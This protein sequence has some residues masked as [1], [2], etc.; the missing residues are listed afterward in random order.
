MRKWILFSL[1][2]SVSLGGFAGE[3][4]EKVKPVPWEKWNLSPLK[5][6][7]E[8]EVMAIFRNANKYAVNDWYHQVK[9]FSRQK[10]KYLDF[11]GITEHHIRP[12][13]HEA[14]ALGVALKLNVYDK[15]ITG[16]SAEKAEDI[17]LRL[18]TSLAFRHRANQTGKAWGGQ[19]QSALWAAQVATTGWMWWDRLA[20][21]DQEKLC[22]M[23]VDEA[24]RFLGT[25]VP[26]YKDRTGKVIYKGDSKAEENA[27]NSNILVVAAVMMPAHSHRQ[28]WL[29]KALEFQISAYAAPSDIES[30]RKI[31]GIR[32]NIFLQG[33]NLEENGAVVNH[34]IIHAD[35]MCAI[36]H[37][38]LNAWIFGLA[39]EKAPQASLMNGDKVYYALTEYPFA[40]GKTMYVKGEQGEATCR[41]FFPEGNDWGTGRQDGY[42]LMDILA[43]SFGWDKAS[44]VKA[45]EW[46][47]ARHR[48]MLGMQARHTD[49]RSYGEQAENSF[50]SR[51]EW[52]AA[53]I[54]FGYL[55]LWEKANKMVRF[56]NKAIARPL[57]NKPVNY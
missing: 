6:S 20:P 17:V 53:Q 27:W 2:W 13:A 46:A 49:G 26:Y 36:M 50:A 54:A 47:R 52:F 56:T 51:E 5:G 19:W 23:A 44:S 16:V 37:N 3:L 1:V 29:Q 14:F 34:G 38:T 25:E 22:R 55:G 4:R 39:G 10:E 57:G 48:K 24:D 30:K 41:M 7:F 28:A 32:L 40:P 33:S 35:Y 11:G 8:E 9:R 31:N 12:V 45:R 18:V 21:A 42:W 43:D 15:G